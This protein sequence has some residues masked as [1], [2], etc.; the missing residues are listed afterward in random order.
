MHASDFKD[1]VEAVRRA[2]DILRLV[3]EYVP[4]KQAGGRWKGLCPFH[5]EKTPS[6]SVDPKSQLFYCFGCQTGGDIFKFV[7]LYEK[8]EFLEAVDLLAQK[9]GVK[10]HV[11][12]TSSSAAERVLAANEAALAFF[13]SCLSDA[14]GGLRA[15]S[16]LEQRGLGSETVTLLGLGYAPAG[17]EG[18][19]SHLL[20]KRFKPEELLQAGLSVE[21]K[22]GRGEYDRFRDRVMFPIRDVS[23]RTVAFGGRC[24]DGS[25]PKYI[26]SP[27][28]PAYVKGSH[29]YG[30]DKAREAI[31]RE[32]FA[33]VVEGYLDL[34]ALLQAGFAHGVASLGTAFTPEQ[35]RLL[36]RYCE[37]VV[38][39]YDGDAAGQS[40]TVRTLDL[41][42]EKGF[43][44][45]VAELPAGLDPD[46]FIKKEGAEA[47]ARRLR[48]APGYLDFI[49]RREI[50]SHDVSRIDGKVAAINALLPRLTRLESSVERA[51]WAGR[52]ADELGIED[53]I[54][55]QELRN[56][57]RGRRERIR[58]RAAADEKLRPA[59]AQLVTGLL[60]VEEAAGLGAE[61]LDPADLEGTRVCGI[62]RTILRLW[63]EEGTADH[64]RVFEALE[65]EEERQLLTTIAF[66]D[67][68]EG[69]S[70]AALSDCLRTLRRDR[71]VRERKALQKEIEQSDG[72]GELDDLL[73]RKQQLAKKIDN[74]S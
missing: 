13:R 4:L 70:G 8:V 55:V 44:V 45:R 51:N 39:S 24:L 28:T 34:A 56:A 36:A 42:L 48:E 33:V 59:E 3:T 74:L 19:R 67:T 29:L 27:E 46:D 72:S 41:L 63:R 62:V 68:N 17:W 71:L 61:E 9:W 60:G 65:S 10:T 66:R 20:S 37:R 2:G 58:Q 18:L 73:A 69:E 52:L 30:L 64:A 32:G 14:E 57:L 31:R 23:G 35:A 40:A 5:Q 1:R 38:V 15:R 7:Q 49:V 54:V 22:E 50:R 16:Y 47:Y 21:R 12:S 43:E 6:F 11:R 26:N 25:E 53:E